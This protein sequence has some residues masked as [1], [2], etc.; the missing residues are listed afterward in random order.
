VK[1]KNKLNEL[2]NVKIDTDFVARLE[3][4]Y[5]ISLPIEVK[6]LVSL[7]K[8]TIFY[9][10]FPLLRGLS[11]DEIL[12][13][14]SDMA[15]DFIGEKIV[16]IFDVGD[17]DYIVYDIAEGAWCRYNIV[18]GIKFGKSKALTELLGCST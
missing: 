13:A 12:S 9:D 4:T 15:V 11:H 7:G 17:N 5:R 14:P 1:L 18:D 8:A 10:D 16:P 3:I 6:S 2:N